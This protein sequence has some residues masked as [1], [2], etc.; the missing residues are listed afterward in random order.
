MSATIQVPDEPGL[1]EAFLLFALEEGW[2]DRRERAVGGLGHA[3]A[4]ALLL[5]GALKGAVRLER[6]CLRRAGSTQDPDLDAV[7]AQLEK[8][9]HLPADQAIDRLARLKPRPWDPWKARLEARGVAKEERSRHLG[10]F[11]RSRMA[12]TDADAQH[13]LTGQMARAAAGNGVVDAGMVLL[14]AVVEAAGLLER[15]VPSAAV[16]F[17]RKRI[18]ALVSGRDPLG[19]K[20][21]P[22]LRKAHD[23]AVHEILA[24]VRR[25]SGR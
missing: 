23:A 6:G 18:G 22:E 3:L 11:P 2:D 14:L 15:I 13:E 20:V 25:L 7:L 10:L 9:Q 1:T 19:Y 12:I 5:E 16:P 4:G 17:S 24:S 21:D 8:V